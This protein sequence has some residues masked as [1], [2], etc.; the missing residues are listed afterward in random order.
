MYLS[1]VLEYFTEIS[2]MNNAIDSNFSLPF[3]KLV[4]LQN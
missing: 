1:F 4:S 2:I 3:Y